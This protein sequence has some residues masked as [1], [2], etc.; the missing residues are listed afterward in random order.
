MLINRE[1]SSLPYNRQ[2]YTTGNSALPYNI[3]GR[4]RKLFPHFGNAENFLIKNEDVTCCFLHCAAVSNSVS[5]WIVQVYAGIILAYMLHS[6]A[7]SFINNTAD[8]AL[9][10]CKVRWEACS[11]CRWE[12][13]K[14]HGKIG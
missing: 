2:T 12:R 14:L 10:F 8:A 1:T 13:V 4:R 9:P 3:S 7:C 11:E 6:G 5:W